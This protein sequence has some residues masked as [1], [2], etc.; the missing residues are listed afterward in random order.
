MT[1][2][3][4]FSMKNQHYTQNIAVFLICFRNVTLRF[5]TPKQKRSQELGVISLCLYCRPNMERK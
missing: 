3:D 5:V 4:V 2:S 1:I